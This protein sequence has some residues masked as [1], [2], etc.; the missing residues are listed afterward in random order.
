MFQWTFPQLEG[1]DVDD[2]K[3]RVV[4]VDMANVEGNSIANIGQLRQI[5]EE[6]DV[7]MV[8][9][10]EYPINQYTLGDIAVIPDIRPIELEEAHMFP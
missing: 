5:F 6:Q 3:C 1:E 8:V 2:V 4:V 9:G 10:L 7:E